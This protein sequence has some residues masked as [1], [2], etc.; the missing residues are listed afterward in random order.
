LVVETWIPCTEE[1]EHP[2][3]YARDVAPLTRL[4]PL[5]IT[6]A[7]PCLAPLFRDGLPS[8]RLMALR[9]DIP[10]TGG[11][12][13]RPQP[14]AVLRAVT[15]RLE[16]DGPS[17]SFFFTSG[18]ASTQIVPM[19]AAELREIVRRGDD[20]EEEEEECDEDDEEHVLAGETAAAAAEAE[21]AAAAAE[22]ALGRG[23]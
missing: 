5:Q 2:P 18:I 16:R 8:L 22:A 3:L 11:L 14:M 6:E 19:G 23:V 7:A 10:M 21:A 20:E 13:S 4:E 12:E 15:D 1:D 9:V 17:F